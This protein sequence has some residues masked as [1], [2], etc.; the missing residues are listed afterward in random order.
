MKR[1]CAALVLLVLASTASADTI[2]P[3]GKPLYSDYK[4]RGVGDIVTILI[5]ESSSASKSASTNTN[6]SISSDASSAGRFDWVDF[7]NL[8]VANN[9]DGGGTTRRQGNLTARITANVVEID[10]NGLLVIEGARTVRVNGEEE[11]IV[12]HGKLRPEDVQ[13]D[14]T[15]LS[16][17]LADAAIDFTGEGSLDNAARPGILTRILDWLF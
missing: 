4:V 1:I 6:S 11:K 15:V 16:T 8:D 2:M 17:Y 14:N 10:E 12:L 9:S 5:V 7:W 3:S 13:P